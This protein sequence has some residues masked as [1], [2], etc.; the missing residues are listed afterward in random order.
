MFSYRPLESNAM[1]RLATLPSTADIESNGKIEVEVRHYELAKMK[2]KYIALS[3]VWGSPE[4]MH[5]ISINGSD[6]WVTEN[7][8]Y[9]LRRPRDR[10]LRFWIDAICINQDNLNEKSIQ[11]PMMREI[12]EYAA[13]VYVELGPAS[14]AEERV[15]AQF[16][17]MAESVLS[18]IKRL[19]C[20]KDSESRLIQMIIPQVEGYDHDFWETIG[21]IFNRPWWSRVWIMQEATA[22]E[23]NQL[24]LGT[25]TTKLVYL[26]GID[27][28]IQVLKVRKG[29]RDGVPPTTRRRSIL[30]IL[31]ISQLRH[32]EHILLLDVIEQFRQLEASDPRDIVY[33]AL[34]LANDIPPGAIVP[35]YQKSLTEVYREVAIYYLTTLDHPLDFLGYCGT[36]FQVLDFPKESASWIPQWNWIY[37]RA[38]FPKSFYCNGSKFRSFNACGQAQ[39]LSQWGFT[40]INVVNLTLSTLGFR[41]DII[42]EV[43]DPSLFVNAVDGAKCIQD[44]QPSDP[45]LPY[46]TGGTRMNAFLSTLV[47]DIGGMSKGDSTNSRRGGLADWD[48]SQG[49]LAVGPDQQ[50]LHISSC[51]PQM[52]RLAWTENLYM[53]LVSHQAQIGDFIYVL[54]GGSMLYVLR[55]KEDDF[56]LVGECYVH[57]LMDGK[58][59]DLLKE[60]NSL[61][62]KVRIV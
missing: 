15:F 33:A 53:G 14:L 60:D 29:W 45:S 35:D 54:F 40:G 3:Y 13:A 19:E 5:S 48:Y 22:T 26:R 44:W 12:Y 32:Q 1:F 7:L 39:K 46:V 16:K 41:V 47:G 61:V 57:G 52:R 21:E 38:I 31:S 36:R 51:Y 18:E 58:A 28:A 27:I 4:R 10:R 9:A 34:C 55:P 56:L 25:T 6:S 17:Q 20:E 59:M 62:H 30:R 37:P 11:V 23:M 2:N 42:T 8:M 43:K 50:S 49:R 24:F